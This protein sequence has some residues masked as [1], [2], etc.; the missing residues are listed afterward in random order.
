[1]RA[2]DRFQWRS[3]RVPVARE[4]RKRR[5]R[6]LGGTKAGSAKAYAL[7]S[8]PEQLAILY[9]PIPFAAEYIPE[10]PA[11]N[12]LFAFNRS[13][14]SGR[15]KPMPR[16]RYRLSGCERITVYTEASR[17]YGQVTRSAFMRTY[18]VACVIWS[19]R[20]PTLRADQG[21]R[22]QTC[23]SPMLLPFLVLHADRDLRREKW[24][25]EM[26]CRLTALP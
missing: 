5:A 6:A 23:R 13:L 17:L 11:R 2:L 15:Y 1:M 22:V 16:N 12:S 24:P 26:S 21:I 19:A 3:K 10:S 7:T 18:C 9:S 25:V 4:S 8:R 14:L 20:S